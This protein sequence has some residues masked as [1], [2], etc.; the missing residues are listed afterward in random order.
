PQGG[1]TTWHSQGFTGD[2]GV[3]K[4]AT[5]S[6]LFKK[7]A[8]HATDDSSPIVATIYVADSLASVQSEEQR[9][10]VFLLVSLALA[11]TAIVIV[12]AFLARGTI[13]PIEQIAR[14]AGEIGG[15]DLAKRLNW[16]GREDELGQLATTFDEML[17]RLEAAFMR[18][19]RLIADASHELKTPLT[20]INAN[21]QMLERWGDRD[22]TIRREGLA[23]IRNES[24]SMARVLNA[25]LTLAKTD[26][27]DAL[28]MEPVEAASVVKDAATAM[29]PNAE[30]KGLSLTVD[31]NGPAWVRGEPGLL[32]QLIT[33]LTENA[34][35]FTKEGRI[36][37]A[38]T[39][40]AWNARITVGDTGPG[41]P[42]DAL[43]HIFDRF[44][45]ADP[46]RS[47][48]VEGTGLGLAV[49]RNI[50]RVHG[51]TISVASEEGK[52]TT[53]TIELPLLEIP[54]DQ[55]A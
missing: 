43:P 25:M 54:T 30:A 31:V 52:G 39:R 50:V 17:G 36:A 48:H 27:P 53:F 37:V 21:A 38:L 33:N 19:R 40:T 41:I 13:S 47:R 11:L 23:T 45:R 9:F 26:N 55:T 32:R 24:A 18:E 16:K 44:Y 28:N 3:A 8:V 22:D 12:S 5:G 14:A 29:R 4:I 10:G 1:Y 20:V 7:L 2:W 6:I 42:A 49:V 46:A 51:G 15:E 35:K 34:I